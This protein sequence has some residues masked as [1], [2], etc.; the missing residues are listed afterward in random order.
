MTEEMRS[1]IK[2]SGID[3]FLERLRVNGVVVSR[4]EIIS[5][6]GDIRPPYPF[7]FIAVA[8]LRPGDEDPLDG[9]GGTPYE[10][11]KNLWLF[12]SLFEKPK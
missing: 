7:Q 6:A 2:G 5:T 12:Y 3:Y 9:L 10:A 1:T 8:E 11:V 4:M